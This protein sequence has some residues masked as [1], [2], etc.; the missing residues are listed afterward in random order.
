M[1]R[2]TLNRVLDHCQEFHCPVQV[3]YEHNVYTADFKHHAHAEACFAELRF[4]ESLTLDP[5]ILGRDDDS[6]YYA[7]LI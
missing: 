4:S 3:T 6:V 5:P 2:E 7:R 1:T